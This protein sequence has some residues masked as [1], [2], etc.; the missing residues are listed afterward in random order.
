MNDIRILCVLVSLLLLGGCITSKHADLANAGVDQLSIEDFAFLTGSW[1]GAL[2]Y[3]NFAD[4]KT[5]VKL[6]TRAVYSQRK[7]KMAYQFIYTEPS[8]EE[9]KGGGSISIEDEGTVRFNGASHKLVNLTDDSENGV[10]E[11][12]LTRMGQDNDRDAQIDHVIQKT[13]N[14]LSITRY[15]LLEG[16]S[17]PFIRHT[18]SFKKLKE[19]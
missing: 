17:E 11:I 4:D 14:R 15:I 16:A 1:S 12:K 9:V 3:L 19:D 6:P 8:G 5:R 13:G 10:V 7:D 2:E 18:Y